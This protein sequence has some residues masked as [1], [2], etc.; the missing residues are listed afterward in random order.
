M[1]PSSSSV[2]PSGSD[3]QPSGA[4]LHELAASKMHSQMCHHTA[5]G[6]LP[7][8]LTIT[9]NA[10][11]ISCCFLLHYS[12]LADSFYFRKWNALCCPDFPP[13]NVVNRDFHHGSCDLQRQTV[14]LLFVFRGKVNC[15][16]C[17]FYSM[18]CRIL[19]KT[20]KYCVK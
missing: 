17:K 2:L 6:L 4:S 8:L 15:F 1:S 18:K 16:F 3:E 7:R 19:L 13:E 10:G 5:G 14:R 11:A 12:A 20:A 9:D